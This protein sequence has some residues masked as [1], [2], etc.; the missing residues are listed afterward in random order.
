MKGITI[1]YLK[2]ILLHKKKSILM[3]SAFVT[4]TD[5]IPTVT[6]PKLSWITTPELIKSSS[7]LIATS[8]LITRKTTWLL[9]TQPI[10]LSSH[11]SN[12]ATRS[13]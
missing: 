13:T 8:I 12:L 3:A 4:S 5:T 2:A 11:S 1:H 7:L 10:V 9:P 6:I